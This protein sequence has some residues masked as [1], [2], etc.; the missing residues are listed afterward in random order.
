[1]N[2][3]QGGFDPKSGLVRVGDVGGTELVAQLRQ[4]AIEPGRPLLTM[5]TIVPADTAIA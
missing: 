3:V 5:V 1:M 2:P 4:E